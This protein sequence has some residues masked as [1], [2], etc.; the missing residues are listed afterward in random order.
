M[1][2]ECVL[3]GAMPWP[4]T[5]PCHDRPSWSAS[6]TPF[7]PER[8]PG[9]ACGPEQGRWRSRCPGRGAGF[10]PTRG[11]PRT[12]SQP[13]LPL[14]CKGLNLGGSEY[15]QVFISSKTPDFFC[16]VSRLELTCRL[17][18]DP[19]VSYDI[20]ELSVIVVFRSPKASIKNIVKDSSRVSIFY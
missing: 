20:S 10:P 9:Q 11:T 14:F 19:G 2:V 16:C 6:S 18:R 4:G 15:M 3:P 8:R 17:S 13:H 1:N 7:C 12:F 5:A